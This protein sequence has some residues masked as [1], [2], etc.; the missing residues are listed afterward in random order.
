MDLV[1]R[2][3]AMQEMARQARG[4]GKKIAFVPT[5]GALHDGHLS[6]VRRARELGDVVVVSVF[7]NPK[8]FGPAEDFARYPRDLARDADLCIQEGVDHLFAPEPDEMYPPGHRTFVDME[9]LTTVLEG[10]ARPGHFRGVLTVVMK[11]L[12]VVKPHFAFFGQKDAQQALIV[13][14]MVKDLN[15]DA[16]VV[17]APTVRHE[18]GLALSS[19]N[20]FLGPAER[21]A[22]TVLSRALGRARQMVERED[23]R[24]ARAI[25]AAVREVLAAEPRA[26]IDY[27]A[28]VDA[29]TLEPREEITGETLIPLAVFLGGTRLIDNA[30]VRPPA[31]PRP[32]AGDK[33]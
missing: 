14:R 31:A 23:V 29:E 28:V 16:E 15:L 25:E 32:P 30:L 13:R 17:V 6:L 1:R 24:S 5:M 20:A 10:S 21:A 18:D 19:R 33:A 4:T 8:Q 12:H 9:G 22:A 7:I 2:V 3:Q 11:L 27:V 26:R